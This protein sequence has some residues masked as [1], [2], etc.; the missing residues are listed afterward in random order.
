[1]TVFGPNRRQST[2][3]VIADSREGWVE[4]VR[5]LIDAYFL[6]MPLPDFDYSQIRPAGAS[7]GLGLRKVVC[8]VF[9]V[10]LT[11]RIVIASALPRPA[12]MPIK[13]FG[14]VSQGGEILKELHGAIAGVLEPLVG[15]PVTVTAIVDIMNLIGKCVVAGNVRRTAEIAFGDPESTEYI[16]LKGKEGRRA[17][18]SCSLALLLSGLLHRHWLVGWL[19]G[20]RGG[21]TTTDRFPPP[22]R[23]HGEPAAHGLRLDVQQQRLRHAGHG[24]R[25][26]LRARAQ[27]RRAGLRVAQQHA[28]AFLD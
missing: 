17:S 19:V 3:H 23:L 9:G 8:R 24:L 4:S 11:S 14:G 22:R 2:P 28:G 20:W 7:V 15:K 27:E 10:L 1:M 21:L 25:P 5:Y 26:H 13:G 12:G 6:N 18:V 16:D